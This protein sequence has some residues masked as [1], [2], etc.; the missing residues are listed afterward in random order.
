MARSLTSAQEKCWRR[1]R[2]SGQVYRVR[3]EAGAL[4]IAL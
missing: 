4:Q 2:R 1:R 3:V